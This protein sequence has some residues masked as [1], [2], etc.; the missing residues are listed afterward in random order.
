MR[1][2]QALVCP[3]R[4]DSPV[5]HPNKSPFCSLSTDK[6]GSGGGRSEHA[7][8]RALMA[9]RQMQMD[10]MAADSSGTAHIDL[11]SP[12]APGGTDAAAAFVCTRRDGSSDNVP[13]VALGCHV[14]Q[15]TFSCRWPWPTHKHG[16]ESVPTQWAHRRACR[17]T[18]IEVWVFLCTVTGVGSGCGMLLLYMH[19]HKCTVYVGSYKEV[20]WDK[21]VSVICPERCDRAPVTAT[22][23]GGTAGKVPA[24]GLC[25]ACL[26][27][28]NAHC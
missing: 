28:T 10:R 1:P 20:Q 22:C 4:S 23:R 26:C 14:Q 19:G 9:A 7:P 27:V 16:T 15:L 3:Y 21:C 5:T 13:P 8:R 24:A 11:P 18:S 12:A 2:F 6:S 17:G 25:E